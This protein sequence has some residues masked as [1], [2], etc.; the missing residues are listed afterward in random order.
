MSKLY[1]NQVWDLPNNKVFVTA[2]SD[3]RTKEQILKNCDERD[4]YH[5]TKHVREVG[6]DLRIINVPGEFSKEK[7][8][9]YKL[10]LIRY[11]ES[12]GKTVLNVHRS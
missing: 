7:A 6:N 10:A 12:I 8:I 1:N 9:E 11:F 2:R 4:D 5:L 3:K